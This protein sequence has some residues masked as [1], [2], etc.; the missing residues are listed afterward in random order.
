V[1]GAKNIRIPAIKA[2]ALSVTKSDI[3]EKSTD[4]QFH[5]IFSSFGGIPCEVISRLQL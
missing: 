5:K 4:D 2:E 3:D 1:Q